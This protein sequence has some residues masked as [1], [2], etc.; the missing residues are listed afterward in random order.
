V[1]PVLTSLVDRWLGGTPSL[2]I[3]DEA[4]VAVAREAARAAGAEAALDAVVRERLAAVVSE[5]GHNQ[6]RHAGGGAIALR[7]VQRGGVA[8]VAGAAADRGPGL[9]DPTRALPGALAGASE[10][11]LGVGLSAVLRQS[12]EVDLEVR[13]GDG[14]CVRARIFAAPVP[15]SEVGIV[16][17]AGPSDPI[18]GDDALAVR[19]GDRLLAAVADGLGHGPA[20]RDAA[21]RAIAA[22]IDE[23]GNSLPELLDRCDTRLTGSRGAVLSLAGLDLGRGLLEHAAV[24]NV[25]TRVVSA[26]GVTRPLLAQNG[27]L[28]VGQVR[29]RHHVETVAVA[30]PQLLV[31]VTDGVTTRVDLSQDLVLLRQHPMVIAHALLTRFGRVTDDAMVLVAR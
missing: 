20:A 21:A 5:L 4:S 27:T 16:G 14:T 31:M 24:G 30:P 2:V 23:P 17:R 22:L 1:G 26:D 15:R 3:L 28:G 19:D 25:T 29:K 10:G 6:R 9:A 7:P 18:S 12:D 8:G 13:A 11:G